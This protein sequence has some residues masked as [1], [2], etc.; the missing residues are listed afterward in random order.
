MAKC[1][2]VEFISLNLNRN[3]Y[4]CSSLSIID[5]SM[6]RFAITL[7]VSIATALSF[8]IS[9]YAQ[10]NVLVDRSEEHCLLVCKKYGNYFLNLME[11]NDVYYITCA[12]TTNQFDDKYNGITLGVDKKGC[13]ATIDDLLALAESGNEVVVDDRIFDRVTIWGTKAFGKKVLCVQILGNAGKSY[14]YI[15][16]LAKIREYLEKNL[17]D[18]DSPQAE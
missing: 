10:L 17:S 15:E 5:I 6:K 13:L 14:Y 9:S 3:S 8:S 12:Q 2:L 4:L 1:P 11:K 7:F 18:E 16:N